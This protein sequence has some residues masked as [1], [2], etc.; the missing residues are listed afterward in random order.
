M[1]HEFLYRYYCFITEEL[2]G[3]AESLIPHRFHGVKSKIRL[4]P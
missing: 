4:I 1:G 3:T 2:D